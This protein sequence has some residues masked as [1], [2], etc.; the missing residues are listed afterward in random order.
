LDVS[1]QTTTNKAHSKPELLPSCLAQW[2]GVGLED[3]RS[4]LF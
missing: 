4:T 3:S 2:R 1:P